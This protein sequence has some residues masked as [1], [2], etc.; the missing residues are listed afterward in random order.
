MDLVFTFI[1]QESP[2]IVITLQNQ[3]QY[4]TFNYISAWYQIRRR[5]PTCKVNRQ[6]KVLITV[7]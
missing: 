1:L 5:P 6:T 3:R 4:T 7:Y 2:I